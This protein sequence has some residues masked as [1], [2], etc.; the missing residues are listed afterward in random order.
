M[1]SLCTFFSRPRNAQAVSAPAEVHR[2]HRKITFPSNLVD[3]TDNTLDPNAL[4]RNDHRSTPLLV[5]G[6]NEPESIVTSLRDIVINEETA[7]ARDATSS[8]ELDI[9]GGSHTGGDGGVEQR[10]EAW[11]TPFK[12]QWIRTERLPFYRTR[13]I[14][15]PWNGDREVKVS[16]DGTEIEPHAGQALLDEWDKPEPVSSF[17]AASSR[18]AGT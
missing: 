4:R 14:R 10:Q 6:S 13:N 11:G 8:K 12:I 7:D 15:N 9:S 5:L 1:C 2:P 17:S 16:R 3:A 18:G